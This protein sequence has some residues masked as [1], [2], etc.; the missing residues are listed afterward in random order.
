M[1][2]WWNRG[3][4]N[5]ITLSDAPTQPQALGE[6]PRRTGSRSPASE[7]GL[8]HRLTHRVLLCSML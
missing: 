8:R 6:Q 4:Q 5:E 1:P 3:L 2:C 7:E